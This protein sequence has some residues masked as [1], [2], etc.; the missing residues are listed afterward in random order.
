MAR[1]GRRTLVRQR[2]LASLFAALPRKSP[3]LD[4]PHDLLEHSLL[5]LAKHDRNWVTWTS[6]LESIGVSEEPRERGFTFDNYMVLIN[7]ALRGEGIALCGR[8]L[9]EDFISQG[10]LVRPIPVAQESDRGFW[11]LRPR[12]GQLSEQARLF[13]NWLLDEARKPS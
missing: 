10:D 11:L 5:H 9:A 13:Y 2:D 1:R 7:S 6:F 12:D 8:R 4:R 3:P